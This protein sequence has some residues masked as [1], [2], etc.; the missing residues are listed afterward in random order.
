MSSISQIKMIRDL[1]GQFAQYDAQM[2]QVKENT[3]QQEQ[4]LA[5][6]CTEKLQ[7]LQAVCE[8]KQKEAHKRCQA[9]KDKAEDC[10]VEAQKVRGRIRLAMAEAAQCGSIIDKNLS[11][12]ESLDILELESQSLRNKGRTD[13]NK[14]VLDLYKAGQTLYQGLKNSALDMKRAADAQC[15]AE[16][17][18][19]QAEYGK[20][21][22]ARLQER[23]AKIAQCRS[24]MQ[25]RVQQLN[26]QLEKK[27]E[28]ELDPAQKKDNYLHLQQGVLAY[29]DAFRPATA[30]PVGFNMGYAIFDSSKRAA[31]PVKSRILDRW[32]SFAGT[33]KGTGQQLVVPY[34]YRFDGKKVST[35]FA[36]DGATRP[37]VA[38]QLRS[39]IMQLLMNIPCGKVKF[40]LVD[41]LEGGNTF[42]VFSP[43]GKADESI[44]DTRIWCQEDRIEERL[45]LIV[46]HNE[47]V[48]QRCL[49]GKFRNIME[50]N[51]SAG[52][53]DEPLHFLIVMDFPR[54]FSRR[55]LDS[56]ESIISHGTQNGVYTILA[57]SAAE[58][59]ADACPPELAQVLQQMNRITAHNGALYTDYRIDGRFLGFRPLPAPTTAQAQSVIQALSRGLKEAEKV[60][61]TYDEASNNLSQRE[62]YWFR[63]DASNGIDIPIGLQGAN[64]QIRLRLGGVNPGGQKR[65]FHAMVGGNLGSGK[66]NLLHTIIMGTLLQYSPEE[67]QLYLLDFK[68]GV[69]F[70]TYAPFRLP[71][72][73]TIALDTEPEFGLAVL[74][75]L[76]QELQRRA[77][78]LRKL[79]VDRIEA[80][81]KKLAEKGIKHHNMPRLLVVFDEYQEL[82]C[83]T[84]NPV[85]KECGR[86]LSQVVLLAGSAMGVHIILS[87]QDA[88][89]VRG[90]DPAIYAQFE[91]RIALNCN[92]ET[93]NI[94]LSPDNP[95][96]KTLV[97]MAS[98][99]GVFNDAG[100]QRDHNYNFRCIFLEQQ[101]QLALLQRIRNK[102]DKMP[103]LPRTEPRLL[104]SD[105]ED[106]PN[107]LLQAFCAEGKVLR[108][109]DPAYQLYLGQDLSYINHFQL[110]LLASPGQNLLFIG[111][112]LGDACKAQQLCGFSALSILYETIRQ[113][114]R[115]DHAVISV[116]DFSDPYD[117]I[118]QSDLLHTLCRELPLAFRVFSR[119]DVVAGL[120]ILQQELADGARHFVI[121]YGLNRAKRLTIC[122][123]GYDRPPRE[124]LVDLLC[125]GPQNGMNFLVWANDPAMY[126][127]QYSDT[128]N[129]FEKR[130]GFNMEPE[131]Y[132]AALGQAEHR[133]QD[134]APAKEGGLNAFLFDMDG[135]N[136]KIR[137]YG[138][139]TEEWMKKFIGR[140]RKYIPHQ[141]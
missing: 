81:R 45:K 80:Y 140:C 54:H 42:A 5:D 61:I 83:D 99:Q 136:K 130:I 41:P 66:T 132:H 128:L 44:I 139:P 34:G 116:F 82:F 13:D 133:S 10:R 63:Y 30:F 60:R 70:K 43:L 21:R 122:P 56:L 47:D 27:V 57:G 100:G 16:L 36:Y 2:Q 123:T 107:N 65:S 112:N 46:E 94:I 95:G 141:Q 40:T 37:M 86:L 97:N 103:D 64:E 138:K 89:N 59:S 29:D 121:F 24:E 92:E 104:L 39:L 114:G 52:K 110:K 12:Q 127:D 74:K 25:T 93:G 1:D 48:I 124:L 49:Q 137:L 6:T 50:Y 85:V 3:R 120:Q 79:G 72:I 91:T 105:V 11:E 18:R 67:V 71:N 35:L 96:V 68:F 14:Q 15:D 58:L 62:D 7:N 31:D 113:K 9:W 102:Q 78:E 4:R 125:R 87:T 115:L 8:N 77:Q 134:K 101:E 53:N 129:L 69:G 98:G 20:R 90:L 126:L 51:A 38:Q 131:E 117:T 108:N 109:R 22:T 76:E 32:F 119:Q 135:D 23:D 111:R 26:A 73:R 28:K 17:A 118:E 19:I 75:E 33:G 88:R 55:A 84:D 106:D